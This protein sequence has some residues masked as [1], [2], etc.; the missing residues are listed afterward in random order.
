MLNRAMLLQPALGEPGFSDISA[1]DSCYEEV[2]AAAKAGLV[3]GYEDGTFRPDSPM[4]RQEACA[5]LARAVRLETPDLA[6]PD[7]AQV[8]G[9]FADMD[10]VSAWACADVAACVEVGIV[11]G[12]GEGNLAP[13]DS[14]T[15]AEAAV[16]VARF[17]KR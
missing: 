3:G 11:Q 2:A 9:R 12:T 4:T 6:S 13:Q 8:L 16:M 10:E 7:I 1:G 14:V 17:W 5:M 15:R